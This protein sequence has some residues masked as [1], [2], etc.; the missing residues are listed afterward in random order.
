MAREAKPPRDAALFLELADPDEFGFSREVSV[1]EFVGKYACLV[2]RNG[3]HWAR[4]SSYLGKKYIVERKSKGKGNAITHI[5]LWGYNKAQS[6]R[7]VSNAIRKE[8]RKR[9]CAVLH[10]SNIE[11]DHKDG[12]YDDPDVNDTKKQKL[13]DFQAL[14]KCVNM[15]KRQHCKVCKDTGN[16]FDAK[17]LGYKIGQVNGNGKYRGTCVGCYWHDPRRFNASLDLTKNLNSDQS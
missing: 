16:R 14:S 2:T 4:G 5:Q 17:L 3:N 12:R 10:V 6:E 1:E 9:K 15:A 8:I 13:D 11:V 7:R